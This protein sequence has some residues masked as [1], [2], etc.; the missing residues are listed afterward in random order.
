MNKQCTVCLQFVL[1]AYQT[2]GKHFLLHGKWSEN[3]V[4][5]ISMYDVERNIMII[6]LTYC[7]ALLSSMSLIKE[8]ILFHV[9]LI[10]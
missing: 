8:N 3:I 10:C 2:F 9:D 7:P 4:I 1:W 5:N 6:F